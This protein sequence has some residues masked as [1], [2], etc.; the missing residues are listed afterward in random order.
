MTTLHQPMQ[1]LTGAHRR[2]RLS[3]LRVAGKLPFA[4][5]G[6]AIAPVS[7]FV[8]RAEMAIQ[9]CVT[10]IAAI[11]H[12]C[13][14]EAWLASASP[15]RLPGRQVLV[16]RTSFRRRPLIPCNIVLLHHTL[17]MHQQL[18]RFRRGEGQGPRVHVSAK[19][20]H[21]AKPQRQ[22]APLQ[23]GLTR[24]HRNSQ[25]PKLFSSLNPPKKLLRGASTL[26]ARAASWSAA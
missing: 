2:N 22:T 15:V 21:S 12:S 3:S 4:L 23:A 10:V 1:R 8:G 11:I 7:S 14:E 26:S 16:L 24:K 19:G 18:S 9:A 5:P 6:Q 25:T 20:T 13:E 17:W